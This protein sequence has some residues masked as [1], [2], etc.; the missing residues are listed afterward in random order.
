[1]HLVYRRANNPFFDRLL[2]KGRNTL[3][4]DFY[5]KGA[6]GAKAILRAIKRGDNLALL[7]DQKMNDGIVAPFFGND[8]MSAPALAQLALK[9]RCPVIPVRVERLQGPNFCITC[10][11][12]LEIIPSGDKQADILEITTRVNGIL[13]G[14]IREQPSQWLWL[15]NRWPDDLH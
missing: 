2:Q 8:A 5:P 7:V 14:W 1:M 3:D 15:H 13:E 12:P 10:Y 4:S 9:F 6:Q 11:P